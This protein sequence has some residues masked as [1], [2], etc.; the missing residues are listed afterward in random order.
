MAAKLL[1]RLSNSGE[2]RCTMEH[3]VVYTLEKESDELAVSAF[4]PLR[5]M[6]EVVAQFLG[7]PTPTAPRVHYP[8]GATIRTAHQG[9]SGTV[10]SPTT[11]T[12]Q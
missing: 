4:E 7:E 8:Y 11:G 3:D 2:L 5:E 6:V 1:V 10:P 9:R 12:R